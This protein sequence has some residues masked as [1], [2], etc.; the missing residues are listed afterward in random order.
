MS[1]FDIYVQA[2]T[3]SSYVKEK[4]GKD[5]EQLEFLGDSVLQ[6]CATELLIH[7]Y[8]MLS[9]GQL[10]QMR[11]RVVNNQFLADRARG[12]GIGVLIRMG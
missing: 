7:R 9:E 5:N 10:S 6:L 8:P 2:F 3:H 11:H 12:L 4:G 1:V